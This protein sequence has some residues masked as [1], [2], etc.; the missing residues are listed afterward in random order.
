MA[1][2]IVVVGQEV[3]PA[4]RFAGGG[5]PQVDGEASEQ[6]RGIAHI[7]GEILLDAEREQEEAGRVAAHMHEKLKV[8]EVERDAFVVSAS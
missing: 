4:F 8:G 2:H 1:Q 7:V 5:A 6:A 3:L